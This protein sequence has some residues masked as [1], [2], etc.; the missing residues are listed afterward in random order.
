MSESKPEVAVVM[1]SSSDW[2]TMK[3][4]CEILDQ[5]GVPYHKQVI[6]AHRTPELMGEFAHAARGN[7]FKVIIAGAGGAA[8]LPGMI[9]AQTTLPVIGVPLARPVRLGFAAVH[10]ADAGWH[11]RGH[12][13]GRQFRCHERRP[14][15]RLHPV[16]HR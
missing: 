2:E 16:H 8:H 11:P 6:S 15:R 14:A 10:R 1:G 13:R 7:G 9:A 12:H 3:H 5:F 4:A